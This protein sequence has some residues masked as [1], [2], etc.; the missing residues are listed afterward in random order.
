MDNIK[1]AI[2]IKMARKGYWGSRMINF[3]DL[4]SSVPRHLRGKSK[5]AITELHRGGYLNRKPGIKQEF[6]YSLNLNLKKEIDRLIEKGSMYK[7]NT[8]KV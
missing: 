4:I 2:I 7:N 1:I 3:S 8:F 5:A 6:R